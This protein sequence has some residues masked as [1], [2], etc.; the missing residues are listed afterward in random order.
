[1][2]PWS[3]LAAQWL[4]LPPV[5][6]LKGHSLVFDTGASVP[7][8]ALF[9]EYQEASGE[10]HGPEVF[11]RTD[12]TTYVCAISS[13]S[14]LPVDPADVAPDPGAIDAAARHVRPACRPT[15]G[16]AKVAGEPGL[17]SAR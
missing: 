11:P 8:E 5:F 16:Q 7:A 2:G 15:L 14:P 17:P 4:P 9:L 13:E 6:G 10:V 1:M 3:I 12:G